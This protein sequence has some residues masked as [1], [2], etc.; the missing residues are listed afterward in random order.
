[1][2]TLG[3]APLLSRPAHDPSFIFPIRLTSGPVSALRSD[4]TV[5]NRAR[6]ASLKAGFE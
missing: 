4:S 2:L 6:L 1:L 3:F 5:A